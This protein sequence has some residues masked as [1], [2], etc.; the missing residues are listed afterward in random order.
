[1]SCK[2]EHNERHLRVYE[3]RSEYHVSTG[4]V[5]VFQEGAISNEAKGRIKLIKDMF[6]KGFLDD[7]IVGLKKGKMACNIEKVCPETQIHLR[8]LVELVT[9]EVG[10]ALVG[11]TVMQL[12]IKAMVPKQCIRLH[13]ASSNRGSFS[14]VDGVSMRT[15]DKN[16]VTPT[17][18]KHD[19]VRLNAD[20][21][22]MTRSLAEN[23][24]YSCLY[25]AQLRG[26]RDQWL[27]IVDALELGLTD[28]R[29]SLLYLL[30][31]LLNAANEFNAEANSLVQ[32]CDKMLP[33]LKTRKEVQSILGNHAESSDYAARLLEI[34]MH[35]LLQAAVESGALGDVTLNPLS[36]MR[37]AN[38]KHGNV[39]DIELLEGGEIVESWDAKYGKGYLREEIEEAAEKIPYH[40]SLRTVGFVINVEIQRTAELDRRIRDLSE[41]HGVKFEIMSYDDWVEIIFKRCLE[42]SMID[43]PQL[44]KAW[45]QAYIYTLAQRKRDV[46]PIDEPC[47]E[48]VRLLRQELEK[49]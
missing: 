12:S 10:R 16:Y 20:G 19:L 13:K 40:D 6:G 26:A 37:S 14:W 42:S 44:A 43:E 25:K 1:M 47:H 5:E 45:I 31:L 39:G 21:F 9:S 2:A 24:P 38:K 7:L 34:S 49:A 27:S 28:P 30:S 33:R 8:Q 15:L 32:L 46:A 23:Y 35:A 3:N 41:L 17:L 48:W 11:L 36:Q 4:E 22:M 18:R 29:E